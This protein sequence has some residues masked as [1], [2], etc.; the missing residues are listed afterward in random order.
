MRER[1]KKER[2]LAKLMP[3]LISMFESDPD[4]QNMTLADQNKLKAKLMDSLYAKLQEIDKQVDR[5][6]EEKMREAS[7]VLDY[8]YGKALFK[9][10]QI[11]PQEI[12]SL[13][14]E[15]RK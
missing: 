4:Y 7:L 15:L 9:A 10:N 5:M 3:N 14:Q 1:R 12:V 6:F 13:L 11:K 8:I 2:V